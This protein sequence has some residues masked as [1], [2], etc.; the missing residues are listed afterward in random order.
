VDE[1][2]VAFLGG[3]K[4]VKRLS[5]YGGKKW[6]RIKVKKSRRGGQAR[7][8]RSSVLQGRSYKMNTLIEGNFGVATWPGSRKKKQGTKRELRF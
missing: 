8:G 2:G 3:K 5:G 7:K 4:G 1:K 6:S